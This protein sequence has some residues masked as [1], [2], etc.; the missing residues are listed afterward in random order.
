MD[1]FSVAIS[2]ALQYGVPLETFVEKFTN[3]RF[4]PAGMT[5]DPDVRMAQSL[6]DYVFR[7]LALDHL[8]FETRSYMGIYTAEERARQLE[9]GSYA[10]NDTEAEDDEAEIAGYASTAVVTPETRKPEPAERETPAPAATHGYG[11]GRCGRGAGHHVRGRRGLGQAGRA[12]LGALLGGADGGHLGQGV[13]CADVHDLRG[14][15]ASRRLLL[16][17]RGVR[18]HQRLQLSGPAAPVLCVRAGAA[19]HRRQPTHLG[20]VPL[21]ESPPPRRM[22]RP[23]GVP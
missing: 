14:Q 6:M 19:G 21:S 17:L 10:P 2:V 4:E 23:A 15:D 16:R 7:R 18:L 11:H 12:R 1:A 9:T 13:R 3:M 5:D 8:D 22:I 20:K